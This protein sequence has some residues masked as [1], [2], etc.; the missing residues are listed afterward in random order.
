M[1]RASW[2]QVYAF[3][4]LFGSRIQG[5]GI[6]GY[7]AFA[8][9]KAIQSRTRP[10]YYLPGSMRLGRSQFRS[11]RSFA[12]ACFA[13]LLNAVFADRNF[14]DSSSP[15]FLFQEIILYILPIH[16]HSKAKML[17]T[18]TQGRIDSARD[19]PGGQSPC[20]PSR[21]PNSSQLY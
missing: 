6:N 15:F 13:Y 3:A 4:E 17:D 1:S 5:D 16:V 10:T 8:W 11:R 12:Q 21:R 14:T 18:D 19:M 2:H 9:M 7:K 20:P